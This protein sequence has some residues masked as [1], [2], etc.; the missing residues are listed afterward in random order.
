MPK[1]Q[2]DHEN[3]GKLPLTTVK[4]TAAIRLL[5]GAMVIVTTRRSYMMKLKLEW[6]VNNK[7]KHTD[8]A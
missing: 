8:D 4:I 7:E 5:I 2:V 3:D 1:K 6:I